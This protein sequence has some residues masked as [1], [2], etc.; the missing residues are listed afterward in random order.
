MDDDP[1][2]REEGAELVLPELL[3]GSEDDVRE[4][5]VADV[6]GSLVAQ[7]FHSVE[8]GRARGG[9]HYEYDADDSTDSKCSDDRHRRC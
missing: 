3:K 8:P 5:H 2:Q 7:K 4:C 6:G 9:E 1:E